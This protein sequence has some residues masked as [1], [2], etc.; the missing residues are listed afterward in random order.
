[1][2]LLPLHLPAAELLFDA[3][4][5]PEPAA[6]ALLAEL[7]ATVPWRHEPIRLFGKDVMQPRLT[8]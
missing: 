1:M 5:L 8:A 7:T 6:S 2:P 3:D 4:F